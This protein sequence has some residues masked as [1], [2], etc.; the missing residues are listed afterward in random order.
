MDEAD[1]DLIERAKRGDDAA[2]DTFTKNYLSA[3]YTFCLRYLGNSDDAQDA[4]QETFVKAWRSLGKFD[5]KRA[6]KPWLFQIAKNTATDLMRK[7]RSIAFSDIVTTADSDLDFSDTLPDAE[8]LPDNMF[9]TEELGETVRLALAA[10]PA[11]DRLLLLLRYEE[12][13]SFEEIANILETPANTVRSL[14]R[15]ALVSLR[16]KLQPYAPE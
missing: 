7:R 14:H 3:V 15:R 4:V 6:V 2:F 12:G 5:T 10:L 16:E 8:P 11:R 13:F 9:E 1:R